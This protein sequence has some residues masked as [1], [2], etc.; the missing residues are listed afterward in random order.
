MIK[1]YSVHIALTIVILL[2]L[3]TL[4]GC[5]NSS[6]VSGNE[7][8]KTALNKIKE[9]GKIVLGTCADYPPYESHKQVN[10]KDEIVGFDIEVAKEIAKDL[11]VKLEIKDMDFKGLLAALQTGNIDFV[12]AGMTPTPERKESVDF[13]KIYYDA[14]QGLLLRTEDI[15]KFQ[16]IDELKGMKV[17]AQKG[18]I[19]E[20]IVQ[21]KIENA[22]V[23]ALGKITDLALEL[24]N[25]KIDG[26]V[27]AIPVAESYVKANPDLALSPYINFGKEGDG[28]AIAIKKGEQELVNAINKTIDKLMEEKLLDKFIKDATVLSEE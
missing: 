19:Q 10:G 2:T 12:V 6:K 20:E 15:E 3:V 18:T 24:K 23:K 28:V 9:S 27:L 4:A 14:E 22:Q 11:G 1:K 5:S 25:K 8:S 21:T 26:V 7:E 16:S 17:G 13:S